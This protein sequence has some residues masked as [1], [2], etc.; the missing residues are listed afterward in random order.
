MCSVHPGT[1][2]T[3]TTITTTTKRKQLILASEEDRPALAARLKVSP[4]PS[5]HIL[6]LLRPVFR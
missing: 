2:T 3:T 5:R 4:R 1:T 6:P